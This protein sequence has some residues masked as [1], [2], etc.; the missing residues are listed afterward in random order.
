MTT[1]TKKDF[2]NIADYE[3]I[4]TQKRSEIIQI[5]KKRSIFIGPDAHV[6]FEN[7][8]TIQAQIQ[9]MLYIEG[10]K[11][12]QLEDELEAYDA[13]I[14]NGSQITTTVLF[15]IPN[16]SLR[17]EKLSSWGGIE[18]TFFLKI[19]NNKIYAKNADSL[20]RTNSQNKTSAVHFLK[21]DL[22]FQEKQDFL[23]YE[24]LIGFDFNLYSHTASITDSLKQEISKDLL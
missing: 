6:M 4:R 5:K 22:S 10:A 20:E 13:L 24:A 15:E 23:K 11:D 7:K 9:E 16:A 3:K 17:L 8:D 2:L 14:P 19:N 21:F 12:G 18:N 1:L